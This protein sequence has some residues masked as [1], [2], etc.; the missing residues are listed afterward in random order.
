MSLS[1][2]LQLLDRYPITVEVK[3]SYAVLAATKI[4]VTTNIHPKLWYDY[5]QREEQYQ[6][7]C[8]RFTTVCCFPGKLGSVSVPKVLFFNEWFES[9]DEIALFAGQPDATPVDISSDEYSDSEMSDPNDED[10]SSDSPMPL[11]QPE[12]DDLA[13]LEEPGLLLTTSQLYSDSSQ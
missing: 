2:L 8:R 12:A 10:S 4:I 11:A 3:G 5:S 9:C 1:Y 7:L 13:W 6:A